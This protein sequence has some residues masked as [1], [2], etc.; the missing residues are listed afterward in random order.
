MWLS[1]VEVDHGG[2]LRKRLPV[3]FSPEVTLCGNTDLVEAP[4]RGTGNREREGGGDG[5]VMSL[6]CVSPL[7]G[8]ATALQ[9]LLLTDLHVATEALIRD[10]AV[11]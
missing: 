6:D 7:P 10:T 2:G 11:Y 4:G 9:F 1:H 5:G 3:R 8:H